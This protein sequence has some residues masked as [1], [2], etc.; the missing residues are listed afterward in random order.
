MKKEPFIIALLIFALIMGILFFLGD[1][2]WKIFCERITA[3]AAPR[4]GF[5]YVLPGIL[6]YNDNPSKSFTVY[7]LYGLS[8]LGVLIV[9]SIRALWMRHRQPQYFTD[10][11]CVGIV[12]V[13]VLMA[14]RA[15]AQLK[16][17]RRI[18]RTTATAMLN[19]EYKLNYCFAHQVSQ[20]LPKKTSAVLITG[21]DQ[22]KDLQVRIQLAYLLY[23]IDIRSVRNEIPDAYLILNKDNAMEHIPDGYC[24]RKQ[25]DRRTLI[26]VKEQQ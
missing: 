13:V 5:N 9:M 14:V 6:I 21:Y 8:V 12:L 2:S 18:Q 16:F 17:A 10:I 11:I 19:S 4:A 25:L 26:A 1:L 3:M 7:A 20:V 23:P 15:S 22:A 24:V